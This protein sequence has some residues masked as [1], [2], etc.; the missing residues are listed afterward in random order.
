MTCS[1]IVLFFYCLPLYLSWTFGIGSVAHLNF[2]SREALHRACSRGALF[3]SLFVRRNFVS[4]SGR[5]HSSQDTCK[6][7]VGDPRWSPRGLQLKYP[8]MC[9][10]RKNQFK[11]STW[12]SGKGFFLDH[13]TSQCKNEGYMLDS[14]TCRDK[15]PCI[16]KMGMSGIRIH[17]TSFLYARNLRRKIQYSNCICMKMAIA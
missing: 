16:R 8:G 9:L 13:G 1:A 3:M 15:P 7:S 14:S 4:V 10:C 11:Q 6:I 12:F 2:C 5:V 17:L